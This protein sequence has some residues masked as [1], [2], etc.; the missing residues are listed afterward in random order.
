MKFKTSAASNEFIESFYQR[1]GARNKAVLGRA[2]LF[3]AL[4]AGIPA[5]FRPAD[6]KGV[7]LDD[8]TVL[9]E[10]LRDIVRIALHYRA[11]RTLDEDGYRQEFRRYFEYGCGR[12]ALTWEDCGRDQARFVSELLRLC[13]TLPDGSSSSG[14]RNNRALDTNSAPIVPHEVRLRLLTEVDD[15]T[16]NRGGQNSLLVISGQPRTW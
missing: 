16:V 14:Q 8:E 6:A 12:L 1:V 2:G 15:W 13:G 10:E 3:L 5:E 4:G 11:G 9:G 7:D